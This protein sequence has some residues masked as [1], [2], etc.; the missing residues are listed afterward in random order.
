MEPSLDNI[1]GYLK[2]DKSIRTDYSNHFNSICDF[3]NILVDEEIKIILK[4]KDLSFKYQKKSYLNNYPLN[5]LFIFTKCTFQN[6]ITINMINPKNNIYFIDCIFKKDL[7]IKSSLE[8]DEVVSFNLD[9]GKINNLIIKN[10]IINTNLH[11]NHTSKERLNIKNFE[12]LNSTLKQDFSFYNSNINNVNIKNCDFNSLLEFNECNFKNKFNLEEITC[13]GFALFDIC[14]FNSNAIFKHIAFEKFTAFRGTKFKKCLDL[15]YISND[16]AINFFD[17]NIID[18]LKISQETYRIIKHNFEELG[19]KIEANK[20]HALELEQKR[21]KLE[22]D[23]ES[24]WKEKCVFRF[25]DWSSNHSTNW[26]RPLWLSLVIAILTVFFT[27][28]SIAIDLFFNPSLFKFEYIA[29][30]WNEFW[31]Y[32][33]IGNMSDKLKASPFVFFINKI[34]LGYLY[35]QFLLSVRKD[36]RK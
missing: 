19:N 1:E 17:I 3:E 12:V 2:K 36:T 16:K 7:I 21:I 31:Q 28:I 15:E 29:K 26:F 35:Y 5:V 6:N 32:C 14:T 8:N 23:K 27:N 9:G 13:K 11:I 30:I 33:Y 18:K 22:D 25:H 20:Y 10:S 24:D 4:E 34:S